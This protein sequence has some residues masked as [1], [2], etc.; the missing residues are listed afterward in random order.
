VTE[1]IIQ[2]TGGQVTEDAYVVAR[3]KPTPPE[4]LEQ[5]TDQMKILSVPV[6]Q[7]E[8][9]LWDPAWKVAACGRE[10]DPGFAPERF[11]RRKVLVIHPVS[12]DKPAVLTADL[13]VPPAGRKLQIDVASHPKG[14]FLLKVFVNNK[15]VKE[16]PV[17]T[18]GKWTIEWVDVA[19][20]A[21]KTVHVRIENHANDW[22]FEA[23]YL[24]KIEIK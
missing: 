17:N 24:D 16:T 18:K 23:A 8:V 2:R 6:N 22:S 19:D 9:D 20:H 3:Q 14:N 10:M 1:Q 4:K 11:G 15:L 5:W 21:G 13:E 12:Q 7:H